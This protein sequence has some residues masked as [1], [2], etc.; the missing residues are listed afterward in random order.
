MDAQSA[1]PPPPVE[2]PEE[3]PSDEEQL[4][5]YIINRMKYYAGIIK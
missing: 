5:E 3:E 2:E 1:P 4:D